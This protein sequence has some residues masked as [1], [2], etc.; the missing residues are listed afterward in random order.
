MPFIKGD[1]K[2]IEAAKLGGKT[3]QK[4][5]STVSKAQQRKFG[6]LS[7]ERRR[8]QAKKRRDAKLAREAEAHEQKIMHDYLP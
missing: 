5:L 8:E 2:T 7:G 3:G 6:K 1:P 4:H